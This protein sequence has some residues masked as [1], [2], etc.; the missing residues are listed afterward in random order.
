MNS[1]SLRPD[2]TANPA[3][4]RMQRVPS[5]LTQLPYSL[6]LSGTESHAHQH[7][8]IL[9]KKR[10]PPNVQR[11]SSAAVLVTKLNDLQQGAG[12]ICSLPEL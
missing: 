5:A 8:Y 4:S 2:A 12:K 10:L 6:Q 11:A 9:T 1:C 7:I 3:I